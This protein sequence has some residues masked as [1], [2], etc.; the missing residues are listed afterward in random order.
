MAAFEDLGVMPSII[1]TLTE[2]DWHLPKPVQNEA[3]PLILGGGD[4]AVAAETGAGKTGAFCVPILQTVYETLHAPPPRQDPVDYDSPLSFSIAD[5]TKHVAVEGRLV[6]SRSVSSWEGIRASRGVARGKWYFVARPDDEGLC[7]VGWSTAR[8]NLNLGND[9]RGFGYGG[10]GMK[11]H[12]AKFDPYGTKFGKGDV[13]VCLLGIDEQTGTVSVEFLRNDQRLGVAFE[14]IKVGRAAD[15]DAAFYPTVALKNAQ[16][17]V[18]FDET[19]IVAENMGY[20]SISHAAADDMKPP[21][22]TADRKNV[23]S[24][25]MEV[26]NGEHAHDARVDQTTEERL[27]LALILEPSRELA[28]QVYDELVSLS[29]RLETS[30]TKCLLLTGGGNPKQEAVAL[31]RGIDIIAGTLGSVMMHMKKGSMS[32]ENLR[33]FVLDEADTFADDNLRDVLHLHSQVPLRNQV[34]TLLFSATLHS[35]EIRSLSDKIQQFPTWI[36]LKGKESVPTTVHHTLLRLDADADAAII[37]KIER[38]VRAAARSELGKEFPWPLDNVHLEADDAADERSLTMKKVKLAALKQVIDA[39]KMQHAMLFAR[40]QLDCDNL[41]RFL[42]LC[43]GVGPQEFDRA[44]F[45]GSLVSAPETSYSCSVLHGGRR[46]D[47]RK[48]AL[49]AFRNCEV[50]FLIC[51]DVAARGIDI[52]GLP[53]LVN[54]TLP[55]KSENYIHRVGRVGRSEYMGL[56]IS[57]VSSQ[58]EAVWFHTCSRAKNG[59]CNNRKLVDVGGCV[60]WYNEPKILEEIENRLGGKIEE[61]GSDLTRKGGKDAPPV[62]Y[63]SMRDEAHAGAATASHIASL[64]PALEELMRLEHDVQE[65]F[66]QL[67]TQYSPRG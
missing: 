1:S 43:S 67:Q 3:I 26:D 22:S 66:F 7:R 25:A 31:K 41:E 62:L 2:K 35:P 11:S 17:S 30:S 21:A 19:N 44:K 55:D 58:K 24:D 23:Q 60:L 50:R 65:S 46:P 20:R 10:T 59:V 18:D 56:A 27:P 14:S 32:V 61:L 5:R 42:L 54:V 63:G 36:D 64:K 48:S 15:D 29:P 39:N 37:P 49:E 6:Q 28:K 16:V 8:A 33:F 9:A 45:R 38:E 57:L 47:E 4:V 12:R 52:T 53:Y 40:T 51:T 34:Q 13:I